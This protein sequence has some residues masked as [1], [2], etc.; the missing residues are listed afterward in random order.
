MLTESE[1]GLEHPAH[2]RVNVR[3][4]D[5][6]GLHLLE[7]L[8][9]VERSTIVVYAALYEC[10]PCVGAG[11]AAE[12]VIVR[13]EVLDRVAVRDEEAIPA[14]LAPHEGVVDWVSAGRHTVRRVICRTSATANG[15][16]GQKT[17]TES[18]SPVTWGGLGACV[19]QDGVEW[20]V[21]FSQLH[22]IASGF[23]RWA[24]ISNAFM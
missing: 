21:A 20:A 1:H 3:L 11:R 23:A 16:S 18:V 17:F 13:A 12:A 7:Q 24:T 6:A 19:R 14:P 4:I 8:V 9:L 22:M 2:G 15:M 10:G 5:R